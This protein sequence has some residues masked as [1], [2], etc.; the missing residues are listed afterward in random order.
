MRGGLTCLTAVGVE[1]ALGL[2]DPLAAA[3]PV[4]GVG[5]PQDAEFHEAGGGQA[6]ALAQDRQD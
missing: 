6:G 3:G 1:G 5:Q 4:A 2:L